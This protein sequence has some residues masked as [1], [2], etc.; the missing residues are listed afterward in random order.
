MTSCRGT[1]PLLRPRA[2]RVRGQ[3]NS[4]IACLAITL[5]VLGMP[6]VVLLPSSPA[7]ADTDSFSSAQIGTSGNTASF[8][9]IGAWT[10]NWT[11][12]CSNFGLAGNFIV[13]VNGSTADTGPNELSTSG[14]G[15]DYY[16]DSGT[17]SLGVNSECNWTINVAPSSGAPLSTP[18]TFT[19][20]QTGDTGN[21]QAF[22]VSGAWTMAWSYNCTDFGLPGN[23][24][25][26]VNGPPGDS[27]FDIGPNEL[28]TGGS[29]VD[30]YSDT[31]TFTLSV[32]S[33]C[34][35][36][37]T[38]SSP[39]SPGAAS[40]S[41]AP[42][43]LFT[44]IASTPDGGG[45]WIVDSAGGVAVGGDAVDHGSMSGQHL[46]APVDH[47]VS[48]PDGGGYWMVAGDGGIFT[49]GDAQ[50][51]GSMGGQHLNA[52]V[53]GMAPTVDG[54]G[55][56]LVAS[57]GGVFTFGDAVFHG[58]MGGQHLNQPVVGIAA[59]PLTGGYWL[60]ASDGGVFSFTAPF[61]GST[62]NI[63][64]NKPINGIA[65][66]PDGLGYRFVASDGG[67]FDGGD[68]AFYGSTGNVR[69]NAP[70]VGLADDPA[71]GGYWLVASD[72]GVFSFNAP[73]YGSA[74]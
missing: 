32:N 31:G 8:S 3:G 43:T 66:T 18:V 50:F 36:S 9:Q 61:L 53:V 55:Y 58:S 29:G 37:I 12:D 5:L 38:V 42:S 19:S 2:A 34:A 52:P 64:L 45:Y 30:S 14:S 23:F 74:A 63:H 67:V 39:S 21:P 20:A 44:G 72:G 69:L 40:P 1:E 54:R 26:D 27:T 33:E 4:W 56:W 51:F 22:N 17:F 10:M 70:V 59:D 47:I 46:N 24:I 35:W 48:T 73:F 57:D 62:G 11:Y 71:T 15:T 65:A 7:G 28:G 41:P 68:A 13:N 60:V 6:V 25:V 16:Y 49:F